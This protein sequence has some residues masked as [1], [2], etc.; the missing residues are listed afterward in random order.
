MEDWK[1]IAIG[2][3]VAVLVGLFIY[4][5]Y[6]QLNKNEGF[7]SDS[8][9]KSN[10]QYV[11]RSKS[12][13][14]VLSCMDYRLIEHAVLNMNRMGYLNNYNKFVLA[15]ASLG[16]NGIGTIKSWDDV[17]DKHVRLS[18]DL[19]NIKQIIIIDHMDCGA[20]NIAYGKETVEEIGEYKLHVKNLRKAKETLNEKFPQLEVLL[21]I[22][23]PI[24]LKVDR[25]E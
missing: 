23:D 6:G 2:V 4:F 17:F 25:I 9:D 8:N 21:F 3:A 19:H 22:I 5:V 14:M 16:Y 7:D 11:R 13:A 24:E 1:K 18:I 10:D 12:Q 15:G 20:F